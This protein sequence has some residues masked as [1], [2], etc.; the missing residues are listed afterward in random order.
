MGERK[1]FNSSS[2]GEQRGIFDS[3]RFINEYKVYRVTF[4]TLHES[5]SGLGLKSGPQSLEWP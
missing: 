4:V 3:Y 1:W 5:K 2:L